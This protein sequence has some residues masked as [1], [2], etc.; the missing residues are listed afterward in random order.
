MK[1]YTSFKDNTFIEPFITALTRQELSKIPNS[2]VAQYKDDLIFDNVSIQQQNNRGFVSARHIKD[3]IKEHENELQEQQ[4]QQQINETV[5]NLIEKHKTTLHAIKIVIH[6]LSTGRHIN[7]RW[8]KALSAVLE[9]QKS[10][11]GSWHVFLNS[12][13]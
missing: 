3:S 9:N 10:G 1:F 5:L 4:E 6:L 2:Y 13:L 12:T 8:N 7:P 11:T